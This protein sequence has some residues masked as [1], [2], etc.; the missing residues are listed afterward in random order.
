MAKEIR[1]SDD[2]RRRMREGVDQLA[3][4]VKV[5][6]GP[7]GRNVA[8]DTGTGSPSITKDGVSVAKEIEL[9]DNYHNIG[10]SL[11][12]DV[13]S[14][15]N[16]V[17]G[18]G[19]TTATVLARRMIVEG[20][21]NVTA[22]TNPM[23]IKRGMEQSA[24]RVV[25]ELASQA[26]QVKGSKEKIKQVATISANGDETIGDEIADAMEKVGEN[27]VITVEQGQTFG[28]SSEVVEG[29]Q[30]DKGYVSP[31]M[32]TNQEKMT[33]EMDDPYILITDKKIS[34]MNDIMPILEQVS[35]AGR[36]DLVI[37]ADE[38][39]GEA[40]ATLVVNKIRGGF[41]SL[42]IKAP[43]FGDNRKAMLQDIAILTGGEV[44]TEDKGLKLENADLNMLGTAKR[45]VSEKE[46]TTVVVGDT[47][48]EAVEARV[49]QIKQELENTDSDFD[50][51][52]LRERLGKLSGG[53][54]VI[55]VGAASEVEQKEIQDRIEDSLA[56]TRA[57]VEEGIVPGGGV[58]LLRASKALENVNLDSAEEQ[59]GLNILHSS[60]DEPV[61]MIADN[62]G[63]EGSVIVERVKERSGTEGYNAAT[64]KHEDLVQAG[65][66]DPTKVTRSALQN[67]A[68]AASL[69][70]TTEAVVT[71]APS[72]DDSA[73]D[74]G[75][76][77]GM[78]GG[79]GMPGMM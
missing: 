38:V 21:K 61:K 71:D 74:G 49:S 31:Y 9:E 22:G 65:V 2:A 43:S 13:A 26:E 47:Q 34:A 17:A 30:F 79:M 68:S 41:N 52:K 51:D 11:V 59:I 75:A 70:L 25:D 10:A 54:A 77:A 69:L 32:V 29:M 53:V 5:T 50:R 39:E 66:I 1:Y 63:E 40:L 24:E 33:A 16:D 44:I 64:G 27:G 18:D 76:G 15:T 23:A 45:I 42:A 58:A 67:A 57:A 4:A 56:A 55:R 12:K 19:T 14:Q 36:K 46:K 3:D 73:D 6:L 28:I 78:G 60:L 37:L 8:L 48:N 72:E 7:R 20:F 35:Q 62:A